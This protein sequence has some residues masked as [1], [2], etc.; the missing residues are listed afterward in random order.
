MIIISFFNYSWIIR[1]NWIMYVVNLALLLAVKYLGSVGYHLCNIQ[2]DQLHH[3]RRAVDSVG[4]QQNLQS[5][6]GDLAGAFSV[7]E[8]S[9]FP[10]PYIL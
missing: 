5:V 4:D 8:I 3:L 9:H 10:P 6:L 1:L 2:L 7:K